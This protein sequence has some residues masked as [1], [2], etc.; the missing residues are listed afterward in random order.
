MTQGLS[1][2]PPVPDAVRAAVRARAEGRPIADLHT[3][4][5]A[6]DPAMA[7]RLRPS[8]PQRILRA[9]EVFE[10]T[11]RSLSSFHVALEP[12][13]LRERTW[14][15]VFLAP[16]R[17]RL[18]QQIDSRFEA[19]LAAGALAEVEAL[20]GRRL[21]PLLPVMRAHGVPHLL[22]HIAGEMD[23]EE[24]ARRGKIDT[25]HYTKRQFTFARHQLPDFT[26]FE[27]EAAE[28]AILQA[29]V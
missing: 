20:A 29:L 23:R 19:M 6:R 26:W 17:D 25:R 5:A 11:G 27:P 22:R 24:A 10:A 3:E 4:L 9:L 8:D 2:I 1:D 28:D 15:G 13:L 18:Y 12:P 14:L 16:Q 21:D 7:A